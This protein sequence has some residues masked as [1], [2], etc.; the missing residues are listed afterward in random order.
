MPEQ[1]ILTED[2]KEEIRRAY[3]L[4]KDKEK[5]VE[6]F[7][8]LY[9]QERETILQVLG[10]ER[11]NRGRPETYSAETK[12]QI[13][14]K[15]EA[16]GLSSREAEK[17]LG[18]S[19]STVVRWKKQESGKKNNA[20][21]PPEVR[22][23]ALRLVNLEKLSHAEAGE[24]LGVKTGTISYWVS[25]DRK[26]GESTVEV[27]QEKKEKQA[28]FTPLTE[29]V[30]RKLIADGK[31]QRRYILENALLHDYDLKG[32]EEQLRE[33]LKAEKELD[34]VLQGACNDGKA[35]I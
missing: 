34:E 20:P 5:Q 7:C 12:E 15:I 19:R 24:R 17:K 4:A 32:P 10:L 27:K 25:M 14:R 22:R 11:K 35:M 2:E 21:Y 31:S 3:R 29:R 8:D 9:L 33:L 1:G 28:V 16:E 13:L 30:L 6:I 26:Q 23:E 18:I